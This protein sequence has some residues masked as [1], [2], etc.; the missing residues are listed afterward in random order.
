MTAQKLRVYIASPYT[1]GDTCLNV[2]RSMDCFDELLDRGYA[3][4]A[5]LMS[6]FQN[7]V[8]H[9]PY[10]DWTDHDLQWVWACDA[11]LRLPG[12]SKGADG[13]V[14][15]ALAC[16]IPVVYSIRELGQLATRRNIPSGFSPAALLEELAGIQ[17]IAMAVEDN[18]AAAES[19]RECGREMVQRLGLL[20]RALKDAK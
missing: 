16:D 19:I 3:P 15:Y 9:R 17:R 5:P 20:G 4:Y 14:S 6:H 10:E 12:E 2:R 8:H 13:E 1:I 18:G 11:V 7:I